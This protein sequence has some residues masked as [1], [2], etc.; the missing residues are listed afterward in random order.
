ME[1]ELTGII[2]KVAQ[3]QRLGLLLLGSYASVSAMDGIL[4]YGAA[5]APRCREGQPGHGR[6]CLPMIAVFLS[7]RAAMYHRGA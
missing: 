7:G 2:Q 4:W 6:R 3:R 1:M 5:D